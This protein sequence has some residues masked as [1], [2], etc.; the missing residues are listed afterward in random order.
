M[1]KIFLSFAFFLI[2]FLAFSFSP[3]FSYYSGDRRD[4]FVPLVGGPEAKIEGGVLGIRGPED[5][6]FDGVL[7]SVSGG[8][9]AVINGEILEEGDEEGIVKI[10]SVSENE[11]KLEINENVYEYLLYDIED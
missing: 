11:L 7:S 1:K 9:M 8:F 6:S 5:V 3:A 10:I 4:P 2:L